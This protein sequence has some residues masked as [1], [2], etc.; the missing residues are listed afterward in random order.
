METAAIFEKFVYKSICQNVRY[1]LLADTD[2]WLTLALCSEPNCV[3]PYQISGK[4]FLKR[5]VLISISDDG[6]EDTKKTTSRKTLLWCWFSH[7]RCPVLL[8]GAIN[9][10]SSLTTNAVQAHLSHH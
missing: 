2:Q 8:V 7:V 1:R 4:R 5:C 10:N 3:G 6:E 9:S